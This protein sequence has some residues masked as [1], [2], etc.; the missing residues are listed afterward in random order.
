MMRPVPVRKVPEIIF[1]VCDLMCLSPLSVLPQ[2]LL[3]ALPTRLQQNRIIAC[4]SRGIRPTL[5]GHV[6]NQS[7]IRSGLRKRSDMRPEFCQLLFFFSFESVLSSE[8][9]YFGS[10]PPFPK[11]SIYFQIVSIEFCF[12]SCE[13][14]RSYIAFFLVFYIPTCWVFGGA[15]F[16]SDNFLVRNNNYVKVNAAHEN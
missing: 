2:L 3:S 15:S 10:S 13:P 9:R 7:E 4:C 12:F 14:E 8:L 11:L 1:K 6:L 5:V 16:L